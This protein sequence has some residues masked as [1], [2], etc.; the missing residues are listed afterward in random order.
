MIDIEK[1]INQVICDDSLNFM[2]KLP[3]KCIDLTITSPPYNLGDAP[4][5][6]NR[7]ETIGK[8]LY[9]NTSDNKNKQDYKNWQISILSEVSRISRYVFYNI[10]FLSSTKEL[11]SEIHKMNNL[12]EIF[13]WKKQAQ[14]SIHADKGMMAKGYEFVFMFGDGDNSCFYY[15]NFPE[16]GYVPNIKEW[17]QNG[18]NY[19]HNATFPISLPSYFIQNFSKENDLILDPFL[20]SGTTAVACQNLHRNFIGI[21]ISPEY[22][23]IARQR[24]R[25][26]PL[27]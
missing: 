15:N 16:N 26:H 12:K 1:Y 4:V 14:A 21:E 2:R 6:S 25:Q 24:L 5:G 8:A 18:E 13:I 20:G 3:D 23:E 10:Q 17:F 7:R 22:C 9:K 19:G 11:I 27:L